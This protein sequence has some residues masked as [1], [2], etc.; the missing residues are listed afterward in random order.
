MEATEQ[1][2]RT[3]CPEGPLPDGGTQVVLGLS[4]RSTSHH[5]AAPDPGGVEDHPRGGPVVGYT[6]RPGEVAPASTGS[7][8]RQAE[9]DRL[10]PVPQGCTQRL[11]SAPGLTHRGPALAAR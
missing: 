5:A 1:G 10:T 3:A 6:S 2:K 4:E 7:H 11:A 9:T 8:G